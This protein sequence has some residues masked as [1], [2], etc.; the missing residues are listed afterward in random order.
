MGTWGTTFLPNLDEHTDHHARTNR[1]PRQTGCWP[2]RPSWLHL[3]SSPTRS[4]QLHSLPL[5]RGSA[6]EPALQHPDKILCCSLLVIY[7]TGFGLPF[8]IA[9][10]TGH[11]CDSFEDMLIY[12]Q[13]TKPT[14]LGRMSNMVLRR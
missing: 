10:K 11:F 3:Y 12:L 14:R 4:V 1:R 9:G 13:C 5:P 2:C 6:V 7:A 8:G